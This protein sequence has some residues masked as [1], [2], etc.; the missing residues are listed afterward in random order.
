MD[1]VKKTLT[2]EVELPFK[3]NESL[4]SMVLGV[5][6]VLL[7]GL[8]AYNY[9]RTNREI[10]SV[11]D[12]KSA[13]IQSDQNQIGQGVSAVALPVSHTVAA[14]ED[15]W[16][17]SEKY[18]K[19]GY[20]FVDIAKVNELSNPNLLAVGEKLTI[21]K[22]EVRMPVTVANATAP[23]VTTNVITGN[24]YIVQKGDS[25]WEISVRAYGDGFQSAKIIHANSLINP[26]LI[27]SGNV[28]KIP[29]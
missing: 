21:P 16:T 9:F 28:L 13:Q 22:V 12:T 19:S 7:I 6:V 23:S 2:K 27:F 24:S 29:R 26:D 17:I 3:F 14:G 11:S 5:V 10:V 1:K 8:I 18:Y 4:I 20:N 15:L 25:I